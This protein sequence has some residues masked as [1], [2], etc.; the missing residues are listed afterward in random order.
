MSY[1]ATTMNDVVEIQSATAAMSPSDSGESAQR[2][3]AEAALLAR[4]NRRLREDLRVVRRCPYESRFYAELGRFYTVDCSSSFV[5]DK[6][7]DIDE[8]GREL[9][10]LSAHEAFAERESQA[11]AARTCPSPGRESGRPG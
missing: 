4:I 7:V 11:R 3:V 5:A 8:L 6:H 1:G 10:C 9:G 2:P